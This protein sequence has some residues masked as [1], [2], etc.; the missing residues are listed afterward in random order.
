V[1]LNSLLFWW[2]DSIDDSSLGFVEATEPD[3]TEI[4][5]EEASFEELEADMLFGEELTDA[6]TMA[7]PADAAVVTDEADVEVGWVGEGREAFGEGTG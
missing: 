1:F 3:G 7:K 5:V 4:D 2:V 6:D